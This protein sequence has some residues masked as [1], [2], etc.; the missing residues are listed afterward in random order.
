MNANSTIFAPVCCP[1]NFDEKPLWPSRSAREA[2]CPISHQVEALFVHKLDHQVL[3]GE[4]DSD[5]VRLLTVG[6]ET[7]EDLFLPTF[8]KF[9]EFWLR[10]ARGPQRKCW[11]SQTRPGLSPR[12]S[13]RCACCEEGRV[14]TVQRQCGMG[15][16]PFWLKPFMLKHCIACACGEFF[17][18]FSFASRVRRR[19]MPRKGWTSNP[20][21]SGWYDV[22]RGPRPKSEV[23]PRRQWQPSW[24]GWWPAVSEVSRPRVQRRWQRGNVP[25]PSPDE[26]KAAA[27]SR[28]DRLQSALAA[29]GE[30]ESV[31]ARGIQATLK[32]TERAAKERPLAVQVEECKAFIKR[33]QKNRLAPLEEQRAREQQELD[34]AMGRMAM[35]REEM[36]QSIPVAPPPA[37]S[38]VTQPVNI[39][40]LVSEIERL[41]SQVAEMEVER[42]EARK[43]RSRPV[44][45]ISR[46]RR[47]ARSDVARVG[48]SARSARWTAERGDHGNSDQ[49]REHTRPEFQPLQSSGLT[50]VPTA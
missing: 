10:G 44:R 25:R 35:L 46:P 39:P 1:E 45:A 49:S 26:A 31:E 22:I 9:G 37:T 42:E 17:L 4:A 2:S 18:S 27:R 21:P 28:V 43:K 38:S 50:H 33:S 20:T 7:E 6:G 11:W 36:A 12:F 24:N 23:W 8:V 32:E 47:R 34:V 30:T 41:R 40:D 15:A 19:S 29:L 5:E 48:R 3:S 14:P 13:Y 16:Q